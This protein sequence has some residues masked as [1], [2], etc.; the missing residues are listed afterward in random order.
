M[1]MK[2]RMICLLIPLLMLLTVSANAAPV[3]P[4]GGARS[5]EPQTCSR[6]WTTPRPA[7][8]EVVAP[9]CG[10]STRYAIYSTKRP[11]I[12]YTMSSDDASWLDIAAIYWTPQVEQ[13][14]ESHSSFG[15]Y[16]SKGCY[17]LCCL[18]PEHYHWCPAVGSSDIC[19]LPEHEH[20][21]AEYQEAEDYYF[22]HPVQPCPCHTP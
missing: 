9:G 2:K 22:Y 11:A 18:H 6:Y 19:L 4:A 8:G 7:P 3:S 5:V 16:S 12:E 21:E 14:G 20:S 17:D 13:Y 1:Q 10:L 15:F